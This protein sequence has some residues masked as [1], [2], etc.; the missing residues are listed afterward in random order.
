MKLSFCLKCNKRIADEDLEFDD[1]RD[2]QFPDYCPRCADQA[3]AANPALARKTPRSA[4]VLKRSTPRSTEALL[5]AEHARPPSARVSARNS[6][7]KKKNSNSVLIA[8]LG[9]GAAVLGLAAFLLLG[10]G[11]PPPPVLQAVKESAPAPEAPAPR[12]APLPGVVVKDV[13]VPIL[14]DK[15]QRANSGEGFAFSTQSDDDRRATAEFDVLERRL[16][17]QNDSAQ[18]IA[19]LEAFLKNHGATLAAPRARAALEALRA[20][21]AAAALAAQPKQRSPAWAF[22]EAA[23]A[24]AN[25][26]D[27]E[28]ALQEYAKAIA[29]DPK[30]P[31]PYS[32]RAHLELKCL[33]LNAALA[34]CD[35]ALGLNPN[36]WQAYCIRAAAYYA[37]VRNDEFK[38][39]LQQARKLHAHPED[40]E[41]EIM[42]MAEPARLAYAKSV[43]ETQEPATARE[44]QV[45]GE[46]RAALGKTADA[47]KDLEAALQREPALGARGLLLRLA[48]LAESKKDWKAK[49]NCMRRWAEA[50]P[51]DYFALNACAW[52]LLT[53]PDMNLRDAAKA[54]PLAKKSSVL[55]N[56]ELPSVLDTLA[57]AWY[58]NNSY[59]EAFEAQKLAIARLPSNVVEEQ[60]IHYEQTLTR[61]RTAMEKST[62]ATGRA[63]P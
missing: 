41:R 36:L 31:E 34:D 61:Y 47:I 54:L 48:E 32:N 22:N 46:Y 33:D 57:L 63:A 8:V 21:A 53:S 62:S 38:R 37:L 12:P 24:L 58:M 40:V 26:G 6:T 60:R 4:G 27:Q 55:T 42:K 50:A 59:R 17:G 14:E 29:A 35:T 19:A 7:R 9:G 15:Y 56:H 2:R 49:L 25:K 11:A 52:E 5:N 44:F 30:M 1:S 43:G 10:H 51:E 13:P 39:D 20:A 23:S 3:R 16:A 28:A 18:N 45:R